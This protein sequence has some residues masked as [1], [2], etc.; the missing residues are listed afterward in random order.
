MVWS[1]MGSTHLGDVTAMLSKA[2]WGSVPF[3]LHSIDTQARTKHKN[4]KQTQAISH[5]CR[6]TNC[7]AHAQQVSLQELAGHA[8]FLYDT[9]GEIISLGLPCV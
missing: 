3:A 5:V 9:Q 2:F 7:K 4:T 6:L 1:V 8:Q